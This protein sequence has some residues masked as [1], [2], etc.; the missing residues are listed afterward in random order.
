MPNSD[1]APR[2]SSST[3]DSSH[4]DSFHG[5]SE[6]PSDHSTSDLLKRGGALPDCQ[7]CSA[8]PH[9]RSGSEQ[10]GDWTEGLVAPAIAFG[11]AVLLSVP[12]HHALTRGHSHEPTAAAGPPR[13][14][15]L[16]AERPEP[17]AAISLPSR[18]NSDLGI[19]AKLGHT[20]HAPF[21][22]K[23]RARGYT[24]Y[25]IRPTGLAVLYGNNRLANADRPLRAIPRSRT[26]IVTSGT[27]TAGDYRQS[28]GPVVREGRLD[29]EGVWKS[30]Y[31]GG[32]AVYDD[33][34]F[35]LGR[36]D[37]VSL[38]ALQRRFF[39]PGRT[40]ESFMGGGAL[41]VERGTAVS[42]LDLGLRQQFTQGG[43]GL[44][45]TQLRRTHHLVLGV[46]DGYCFILI[47]HAKSG[48]DIQRD[49][50]ALKFESAVKFDGGSGLF[51][52]DRPG[53]SPRYRG[54]NSTGFLI[55]KW[56]VV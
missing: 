39:R 20:T 48:R 6:R 28:V 44:D 43:F 13:S 12:L 7:H 50:L 22:A 3:G 32:V 54:V 30:L 8:A 2:H 47:A 4:H 17:P 37:G 14:Q 5:N 21:L 19:A 25:V 46:R 33:G 27:F 38:V 35:S 36:T 15:R 55:R 45:A 29:T 24:A 16:L 40:V 51:V 56:G 11:A 1:S 52:N 9:P 49:M 23:L 31:R 42:S 26:T 53:G 10:H 34:T 18:Q 41:L